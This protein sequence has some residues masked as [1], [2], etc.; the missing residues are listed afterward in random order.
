MQIQ[1]CF[2]LMQTMSESCWDRG[3]QLHL[4][5]AQCANTTTSLWCRQC[6][7]CVRGVFFF[8]CLIDGVLSVQQV[9]CL[10]H[11]HLCL[12]SPRISSLC[13]FSLSHCQAFVF[14]CATVAPVVCM[15]LPC[16]LCSVLWLLFSQFWLFVYTSRN[17]LDAMLFEFQF[18][19]IVSQCCKKCSIF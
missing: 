15:F 5:L 10:N 18:L 11:S 2:G 14:V 3:G 12:V 1:F 4:Q 9:T 13:K 6:V 8:F 7:C 19:G 16:I 17:I